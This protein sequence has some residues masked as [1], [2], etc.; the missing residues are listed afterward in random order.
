MKCPLCFEGILETKKGTYIEGRH[1]IENAKWEVCPNCGEKFFGPEI[2]KDLQRAFY[3]NNDLLFPEEIKRRR[4]NCDKTQLELANELGVSPNSIKR[5]EKGSYIQP[6]DKNKRMVDIF[7][8][9]END[10]LEDMSVRSWIDKVRMPDYI[11][12]PA[13]ATHTSNN[14]AGDSE[15]AKKLLGKLKK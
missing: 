4:E 5:W 1:T 11:S 13:F 8:A 10:R 7:N 2:M 9:W 12:M 6:D 15:K 3:V 14:E